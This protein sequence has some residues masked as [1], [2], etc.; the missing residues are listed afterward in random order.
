MIDMVAYA[1]FPFDD[2]ADSRTGPKVGRVAG[3]LRATQQQAAQLATIG[4]IQFV[5]PSGR[6]PSFQ[7]PA[8][9]LAVARLPAANRTAIHTKLP[10]DIYGGHAPFKQRDGAQTTLFEML[11]ASSGSHAQSLGL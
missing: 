3:F 4:N 2:S 8:S 1:E 11:W 7:R 10:S 6:L 5:R 9:S